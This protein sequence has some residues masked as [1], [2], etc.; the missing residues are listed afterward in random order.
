MKERLLFVVEL[1]LDLE[2]VGSGGKGRVW[3]VVAGRVF[4]F[5]HQRF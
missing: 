1:K 3:I 2:V 4:L 5:L